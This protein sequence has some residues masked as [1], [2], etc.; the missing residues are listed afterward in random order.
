MTKLS[1]LVVLVMKSLEI[2][3]NLSGLLM[4]TIMM[5]MMMMMIMMTML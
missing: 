5:M 2:Q 4:M 1:C 3:K